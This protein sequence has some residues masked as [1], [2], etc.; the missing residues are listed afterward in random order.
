MWYTTYICTMYNALTTYS[1]NFTKLEPE[2]LLKVTYTEARCHTV[3]Y[4][5]LVQKDNINTAI[6]RKAERLM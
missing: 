3:P 5:L 4:L 6:M 2:S 1:S